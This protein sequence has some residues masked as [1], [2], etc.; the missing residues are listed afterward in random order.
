MDENLKN[1][2][3]E[4]KSF[5][6]SF[7]KSPLTEIKKV[8]S[9]SGNK[10]LKVAV[11]VLIIWIVSIF[12]SD[13]LTVAN[14]YLFG[15]WGSFSY[16]FR[17]FFKILLTFVKDLIAP[18]I[19][20]GLLS[21]LTFAF[22]KDKNKSFLGITSGVLIAKIPSVVSGIFSLIS[23]ASSVLNFP[24]FINNFILKL[25]VNFSAFCNVLSVLLLF[26]AI[27]NLSGEEKNENYFWKFALIMGIFY[28]ANFV[29]SY[30]GIYL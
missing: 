21:G 29:F 14:T 26:C 8:T 18:F 5:F 16:L 10:L 6:V 28:V 1:D 12:V 15:P 3:K 30:L 7:F 17:N 23:V 27:K 20:V 24:T 4:V 13:L 9:E 19:C 22:R 11:V 2:S 25:C